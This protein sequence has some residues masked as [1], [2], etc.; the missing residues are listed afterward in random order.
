MAYARLTGLDGGVQQT[1]FH[2]SGRVV[3]AGAG[4]RFTSWVHDVE[5]AEELV[6][7]TAGT[8]ISRE[9]WEQQVP[10]VPYAPPCV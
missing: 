2:P 10:G 4:G 1:V 9:E 3:G 6:C 5:A 7:R 8:P